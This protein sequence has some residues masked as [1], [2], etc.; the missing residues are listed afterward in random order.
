[1]KS[2]LAYDSGGLTLECPSTWLQ[3]DDFLKSSPRF[4]EGSLKHGSEKEEQ[5]CSP[6]KSSFS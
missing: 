5:R 4:C 3:Q 1:M 6:L 2:Q